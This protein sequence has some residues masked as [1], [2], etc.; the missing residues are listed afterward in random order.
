M[1]SV[2]QLYEG[3][4]LYSSHAFSLASVLRHSM[5]EILGRTLDNVFFDLYLQPVPLPAQLSGEPVLDNLL[6][7]Y[8]YATL[9][10]FQGDRVIYRHPHTV[11]ELV[12]IPL[13]EMLRESHPDVDYWGY[14][15]VGP[16]LPNTIARTRPTVEGEVTVVPYEDGERPRFQI[17][18]LE[19]PEP[20]PTDLGSFGIS[21][22][23]SGRQAFVKVLIHED[24]HQEL[25]KQRYFSPDVEEGG[26]LTGRV[27][28]DR[29]QEGSFLLE[30]S[31]ALQAEHTGAS[32]L[33]FTFTGDSFRSIKRTLRKQRIDER[34]LGWYHTH[35]FP[36][37][38]DF[39]LSTIDLRL[40]FTTFQFP[41]QMAGLINLDGNH[42]TLRFY[43][44]QGDTME[45][46]PHW[47]V[48]RA[49]EQLA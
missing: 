36:A 18:R 35:L 6:P 47:V 11:E 45:L 3:E 37:T 5:R 27:F 4:G 30:I 12:A 15:I 26:F 14:R 25:T 49:E 29:E 46:C 22:A 21:A 10:I 9:T 13:Q 28:R 24:I 20:N 39:G 19:E 44:R 17:S 38:D 41:W 16:G 2:I 8:G 48:E 31:G 43:V 32:F 33:Q 34:L 42:R 23:G 7:D 1:S 40:H